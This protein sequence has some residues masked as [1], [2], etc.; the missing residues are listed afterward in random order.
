MSSNKGSELTGLPG[1]ERLVCQ[2]LPSSFS[3]HPL[4]VGARLFGNVWWRVSNLL[5]PHPLLLCERYPRVAYRGGGCAL[6]FPPPS[7]PHPPP[8]PAWVSLPPKNSIII[9]YIPLFTT[10]IHIWLT[11]PLENNSL[12]VYA[13]IYIHPWDYRPPPQILCATLHPEE[14]VYRSFQLRTRTP[15]VHHLDYHLKP[16]HEEHT[17][18]VLL[19]GIQWILV[20][21]LNR[22]ISFFAHSLDHI[23]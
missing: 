16:A 21:S 6:G 4:H 14:L 17:T 19:P 13:C 7:F 22:L 1:V 5:W 11:G 15:S 2:G 10:T 8:P 20:F 9:I 12:L 18:Y 3:W 23:W